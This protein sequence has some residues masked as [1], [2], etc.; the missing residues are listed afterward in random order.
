MRMYRAL[1]VT[2]EIAPFERFTRKTVAQSAAGQ[3]HSAW[4]DVKFSAAN[5]PWSSSM[6]RS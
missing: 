6:A 4:L 3:N 1:V 5:P 2:L